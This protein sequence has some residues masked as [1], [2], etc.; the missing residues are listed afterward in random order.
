MRV[1]RGAPG[2]T[3]G[4]GREGRRPD[5]VPA[6]G[7]PRGRARRAGPPAAPR[8]R[9]ARGLLLAERQGAPARPLSVGATPSRRKYSGGHEGEPQATLVVLAV[10]VDH[11][12]ALPCTKCE[13]GGGHRGRRWSVWGWGTTPTTRCHVPSAS[14]PASTGIES[15]GATIT[16][17]RWSPP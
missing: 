14:R 12:D 4:P 11:N 6:A 15:D 16:G 2:R 10:R 17:R 9:R 5:P 3:R 1:G 7:G 13:P 8:T